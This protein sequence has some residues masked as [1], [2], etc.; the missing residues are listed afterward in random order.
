MA[1]DIEINKL[2]IRADVTQSNKE[3]RVIEVVFATET[4]VRN[5]DWR[6]SRYFDEILVC[7]P[8]SVDMSR[9]LGGAPF[10]DNHIRY[11]TSNVLGR[12]E[13]A[14]VEGGQCKAKIRLSERA[15]VK[16]VNDD[17]LNGIITGISVGYEVLRYEATSPVD[18]SEIWTYRA[19]K[20]QPKEIS[21][22]PVQADP[23]SSTQRSAE[24]NSKYT[25]QLLTPSTA[26]TP[27]EIEKLRKENEELEKQRKELEDQLARTR[28]AGNPN[29]APAPS[30]APTPAP[31]AED[32]ARKAVEAERLRVT[33]INDAV[34]KAGLGQDI[35]ERMIAEGTSLDQARAAILDE[36][37]KQA[38]AARTHISVGAEDTEKF[39]NAA[40]AGIVLRSG[41][42]HDLSKEEIAAGR[43]FQR[44]RLVDVAAECLEREGENT[45]GL[46]Q[47]DI[48]KRA[49]EPRFN[50]FS[51]GK[52]ASSST[53]DFAV[54]LAGTNRRILLAAFR[55]IP[56]IWR[57]F[58]TIGSVG[59][60]RTYKYVKM[61]SSFNR[62]D[63]VK[64]NGEYTVK[65]ILDG[66]EEAYNVETWGN[67]VEI[68]REML[69]N[70]DLN[71]F[72]RLTGML[73]RAAGRS[74][75]LDFFKMLTSNNGLGPELGD[76]KYLFHADHGNIGTSSP[77]SSEG[78]KAD[79]I[80]MRKQK[81]VGSEK[82]GGVDDYLD[83]MPKTLFVPIELEDEANIITGATFDPNSGTAFMRPNYVNAY[84]LNVVGSPRLQGTR[85]YLLADP[86]EFPVFQ[87]TFLNGV[88]EP[89][90]EQEM[91]FRTDGMSMKIRYDYGVTA[92]DW[93]GALTNDGND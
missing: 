65:P 45:R 33:S 26:M 55:T 28:A 17:I 83:V 20:W 61:E 32:A 93:R 51:G 52:R 39:R 21:S 75:E 6:N 50:V 15:D 56:D 84:K 78:I 46:S 1:K 37:G 43:D 8:D 7:E 62:L 85:R 13:T 34:R 77:L 40:I 53:S 54:L 27:E 30:P 44:R 91:N 9:M 38:P 80:L 82:K 67:I 64:E 63:K 90:M 60:F 86:N 72:T 88:Q 58:C 11:S 4:P 89:Y 35:A 47:E 66:N 2:R 19:V 69:I 76:G 14:W 74:V 81:Q 22:A 59:D 23:E 48:I 49:L 25:T 87:A 5:Y 73:G 71:A 12:V 18:G 68:S 3:D 57:Q 92:I 36:I 79:R 29:P 31:N 41:Q 16:G 70:D 42:T 24:E 10:L